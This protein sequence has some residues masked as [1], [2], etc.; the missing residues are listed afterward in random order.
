[1]LDNRADVESIGVVLR[2][3]RRTVRSGPVCGGG[4]AAAGTLDKSI[5]RAE[6]HRS[7]GD[8]ILYGLVPT[9]GLGVT[10][11]GHQAV[12]ADERKRIGAA[13]RII[14]EHC[15]GTERALTT[16]CQCAELLGR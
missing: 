13:R 6:V 14:S 16:E 12:V 1:F 4:V 5:H 3:F 8:A 15:I 2:L 11:A 9:G 7:V 10:T